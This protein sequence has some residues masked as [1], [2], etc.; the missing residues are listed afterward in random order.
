MKKEHYEITIFFS[1]AIG[2]QKIFLK[3]TTSHTKEDPFIPKSTRIIQLAGEDE[4]SFL[5]VRVS[6]DEDA[7]HLTDAGRVRYVPQC[8]QNYSTNLILE[9]ISC[10]KN[11]GFVET[12]ASEAWAF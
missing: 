6:E 2:R 4:P 8:S 12:D 1:F 7:A 9:A 11:F 10:L 5:T 3:R